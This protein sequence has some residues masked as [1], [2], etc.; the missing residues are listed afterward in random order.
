MHVNRVGVAVTVDARVG[1]PDV[2]SEGHV[3]DLLR[4]G[5]SGRGDDQCQ[6]S[7]TGNQMFMQLH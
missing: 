2:L 6:G 7:G 4:L 3:E 5:L 1:T